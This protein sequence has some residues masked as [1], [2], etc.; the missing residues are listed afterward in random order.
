VERRFEPID[1]ACDV[2]EALFEPGFLHHQVGEFRDLFLNRGQAG[3]RFAD[4]LA[5]AEL[6]PPLAVRMLRVGD[7]MGDLALIA[8]HAAEFYEHKFSIGLDRLMG[9]LPPSII[10]CRR[11]DVHRR[12]NWN[13]GATRVVLLISPGDL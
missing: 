9:A 12:D 11:D 7:E 6:V 1:P 5:E 13:V 8:R 2:H 10:H 4:A 3:R